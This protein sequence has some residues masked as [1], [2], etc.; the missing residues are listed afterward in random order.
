MIME[1]PDCA[2]RIMI[3]HRFFVGLRNYRSQ[4]VGLVNAEFIDSKRTMMVFFLCN[5]RVCDDHN[6]CE[7]YILLTI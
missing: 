2:I 7:Q 6:Y 1:F 3:S 4:R 5:V